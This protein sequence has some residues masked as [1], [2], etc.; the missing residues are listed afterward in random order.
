MGGKVP[1]LGSMADEQMVTVAALQAAFSEDQKANFR[2][3]EELIREAAGNGAQI[4]LPPE[5]FQGPY[6]CKEE[7]ERWFR[8]AWSVEEHP[9]IKVMAPLA[10]ELGVVLLLSLFEREKH[11]YYNSL[12]VVDADGQRL[13]TYR[14]SHIPDGPGYEEKF[15]FRP[16]NSGFKTWD[17]AFGRIGVG[18]CWDQWFPECAR[19]MMLQGAELLFYPT[20]IGSEPEERDLD[21]KNMWQR[22][23]IGHAVANVVPVIA[24]NRIGNENGQMFYGHSF[25]ANQYGDMV[26]EAGDGEEAIV[27]ATFDLQKIRLN[28]AT[29]GFFRDRRPELYGDIINPG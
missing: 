8:E 1:T 16:G 13:G 10:A 22:V 14:K 15:Y 23:M 12:V 18:V 28:R 27:Q 2:K 11:H 9:V 19:C 7:T 24:A 6:F 25:I 21:T 4:I 26:S 29:M 20:A 17:T 5:L 3:V